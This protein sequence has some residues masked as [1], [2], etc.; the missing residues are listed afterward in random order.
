LLVTNL[1][2]IWHVALMTKCLTMWWTTLLISRDTCMY[3]HYLVILRQTEL[4][5]KQGNFM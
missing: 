3:T 4:R 5:Q 2:Q 1:H